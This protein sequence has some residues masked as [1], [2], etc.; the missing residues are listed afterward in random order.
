[1]KEWRRQR[2]ICEPDTFEIY[3]ALALPPGEVPQTEMS[4]V[5]ALAP[6]RKAFGEALLKLRDDGRVVRFL[7][8]TEDY[9]DADIPIEHVPHIMSVLMDI[10]DSFPNASAGMYG[11]DTLMRLL[12]IFHQLAFRL[13]THEER[14]DVLSSAMDEAINSIYTLVHNV[15]ILG[16][17]HGK[18]MSDENAQPVENRT[19][20]AEQLAQLENIAVEKIHLWAR[21]KSSV[22]IHISSQYCMR[23]RNLQLMETRRLRHS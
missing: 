3:F 18:L 15:V 17:E 13:E 5:L 12:R 22:N 7:E 8:R 11:F 9:T 16:Q 19:V 20:D 6:E 4:T 23:G 21:E 10:G 1:M 2:R 14:F